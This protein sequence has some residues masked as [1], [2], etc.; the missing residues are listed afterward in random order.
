MLKNKIAL[1]TGAS[2]GIG[3]ATAIAMAGL[4]VR[5][6]LAG[7]KIDALEEVASRIAASGG[8]CSVF[9]GDLSLD[10]DRQRIVQDCAAGFGGLDILVNAAGTIGSG[11]LENTTL[12]DW[13]AMFAVNL[14]AVFRM[15]QLAVPF[16][17]KSKGCIVNVSSV[18]GIRAFPGVLSY[19]V[20]KAGVDQLS[21][22]AALELAPKGIRVN[23]VNPGVVVS[24]LHRRGG[25]GEEQYKQ[26]LE[27]ST[28]T[29]PLGRVGTPED[30]A[31]LIVFL[32]SDDAGWITGGSYSVDGGRHQTCAR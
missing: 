15:M 11:T 25:M 9:P 6:A 3:R 29:H 22:C 17:E 26:F 21:H 12:E 16:L 13:R 32:A 10:V 28:A 19:C 8:A 23:A 24:N 31:N 5:T 7:R 20:S 2:S 4:G 18:T 1:I 30:I 14:D 27:R